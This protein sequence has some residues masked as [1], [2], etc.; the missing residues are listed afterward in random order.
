MDIED[1]NISKK[2]LKFYTILFL[3]FGIFLAF[4]GSKY[5]YDSKLLRGIGHLLLISTGLMWL[6]FLKLYQWTQD[7]QHS[8]FPKLEDKYKAFFYRSLYCNKSTIPNTVA[9]PIRYQPKTASP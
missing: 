4:I 8:F 9:S 2:N 6:Y 7:F 5:T 1:K 3:A